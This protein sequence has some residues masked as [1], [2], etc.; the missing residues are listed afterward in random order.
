MRRPM[1]WGAA[2]ILLVAGY[3]LSEY[4]SGSE[5]GSS[6]TDQTLQTSSPGNP[7]SKTNPLGYSSLS[8]FDNLPELS[9]DL[10][11]PDAISGL[12]SGQTIATP[13]I[14]S[15]RTSS[16]ETSQLKIQ[17]TAVGNRL[18]ADRTNR[19]RLDASRSLETFPVTSSAI[20][21]GMF[22]VT[23]IASGSFNSSDSGTSN[24]VSAQ[25]GAVQSAATQSAPVSPLQSALDRNVTD[26]TSEVEP[27]Q[28]AEN[29]R[30]ANPVTSDNFTQTPLSAA[31]AQLQ[32][33]APRTS[34]PPGT[35]GYTL[36]S[37]FRTPASTPSSSTPNYPN[38][39]GLGLNNFSR[40][41]P[42]P[43]LEFVP[44]QATQPSSSIYGPRTTPGYGISPNAQ[45][46]ISPAPPPFSVPRTP[47][48][49]SIG[50]GQINTFSNP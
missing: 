19:T 24:S 49:R 45:P 12:A 41:Q 40:P 18:T 35:T 42:V 7:N 26:S 31:S 33:F 27:S 10:T 2:S 50:G 46:Q 34:P 39:T 16:S 13:E 3:I 9:G 29:S 30:I 8:D 21:P 37:V 48:G 4:W 47:P 11:Q 5:L 20:S 17:Q 14:F 6:L 32:P 25:S 22:P 36:P 28:P 44:Q 43:G 38:N 23:G 1:L 15:P